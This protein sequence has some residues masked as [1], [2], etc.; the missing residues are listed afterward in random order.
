MDVVVFFILALTVLENVSAA[1]VRSL[2]REAQPFNFPKARRLS[3]AVSRS[4]L[5][6]RAELASNLLRREASFDF[7]HGDQDPHSVFVATLDVKSKSPILA[8]EELDDSVQDVIC[9]ESQVDILFGSI[10]QVRS[11]HRGLEQIDGFILVT[12][13]SGCNP[14]GARSTYRVNKVVIDPTRNVLSLGKS[15]CGWQ[16]AFHTTRVSFSRR[17][18]S[19]VRRRSNT[20]TK[21]QQQS[22]SEPPEQTKTMGGSTE[23]PTVTFPAPSATSGLASTSAKEL[24]EH[25]VD[26]KIFPPD[27]PAADM[28]LPSGLTVSCKNCSLEGNI[29]LDKGSFEIS[30]SDGLIDAV[31]STIA[32]FDH[33]SIEVIANGLFAQIELEFDLSASQDLG[34]FTAQLPAIPLIPFEIPGVL[35]FGPIVVAEFD[36]S[37][38]LDQNTGFSYGFNLSVP[39]NSKV[40]LNMDEISNSSITG[41][42]KT[43]VHAL[44]FQAKAAL[45]SLIASIGFKPRVLLG[46][47]TAVGSVQGGVG[48]FLELPKVSVNVTQLRN[49][50]EKCESVSNGEGKLT[51][52]L[53]NIVG[54]FTNIV[55]TVDINLGALA[56]FE[57]DV[58][59][60]FTETA[61]VQTVLASTSYPLPTACLQ[62]DSESGEYSSPTPT[63]TPTSVSSAVGKAATAEAKKSRAGSV[64]INRSVIL[65]AIKAMSANQSLFHLENPARADEWATFDNS[66]EFAS[67]YL[68]SNPPSLDSIS[69]KDLEL[70]YSDA[71]A[72]NWDSEAAQWPQSAFSDLVAF[73]DPLIGST[74]MP[75][76]MAGF[77]E[78]VPPLPSFPEMECSSS[79]FDATWSSFNVSNMEEA[80]YSP[81]NYRQLIESQAAADP[82][83]FSKKEKRLE[84]SIALHLQ[85]LQDAATTDFN[86]SSESCGSFSSPC[87]PGSA[88]GSASEPQS[89]GSPSSTSASEPSTKSSTP[90][91]SR[92]SPANG[93]VELVLDLNMNTTTNLPKKQKP[94]SQAQKEN[95]I[96][97]RK[98]GACE[99]HRKQHKRCNCLDKSTSRVLN[100][101]AVAAL[102]QSTNARLEVRNT[103]QNVIVTKRLGPNTLPTPSPAILDRSRAVKAVPGSVQPS[104]AISPTIKANVQ[105]VERTVHDSAGRVNTAISPTVPTNVRPSERSAHN[106]AGRASM[107]ISW[108]PAPNTQVM[109]RIVQNSG[110]HVVSLRSPANVQRSERSAQ[111]LVGQQNTAHGYTQVRQSPKEA[112]P[113]RTD[114]HTSPVQGASVT[115]NVQVATAG[116]RGRQ[117]GAVCAV[118]FTPGLLRE[119]SGVL[120]PFRYKPTSQHD[121]GKLVEAPSTQANKHAKGKATFWP[122]SWA[123]SLPGSQAEVVQNSTVA[124]YA[125]VVIRKTALAFL[126]FWQSSTSLTSWAGVLLGQLVLSS[127][128][129]H[130]LARKGLGL[131]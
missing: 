64:G 121:V 50:N 52:M 7:L 18:P 28:L 69:P 38:S 125:G 34:S 96:K 10:E 111:N 82:R 63:P 71:D 65:S 97:V 56:N 16:D 4:K 53:D 90:P 103:G 123:W 48:A 93:G 104:I 84:A 73:E 95:Y 59:R 20:P 105:R 32:F 46:I 78:N 23:T 5:E 44:P 83:C 54:D 85:R 119:S 109:G 67:G 24:N 112:R 113:W 42:D 130:M 128:R 117:D 15:D 57:V 13:H 81:S 87:W 19:E 55:P 127:S 114:R 29:V 51:S 27:I 8:L 9:K 26:R 60:V 12:S 37:L 3:A 62:F 118:Q 72:L 14:D 120:R 88:A 89:R 102:A 47:N 106:S 35:V 94:R 98:H 76:D 107:A 101:S 41:F 70:V 2:S 1:T 68:E 17:H 80:F 22:Q 36:M 39:A 49:V 74:E 43:T 99:K 21:R 129:Q 30:G 75:M 79:T 86:L 66:F 108:T 92:P 110:G 61:A 25:Y 116:F 6:S 58:P 40:E 131:A 126:A 122:S 91:S 33:G 124:E 45:V 77:S 31:N 115:Q 100:D 11:V